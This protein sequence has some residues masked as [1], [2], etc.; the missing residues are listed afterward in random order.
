[1][2]TGRRDGPAP[3]PLIG[4]DKYEWIRDLNAGT[5]GFVQVCHCLLGNTAPPSTVAVLACLRVRLELLGYR[6]RSK[7][8]QLTQKCVYHRSLPSTGTVGSR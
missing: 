3:R 8:E 2:A 7:L 5:Y 4:H 6:S 1:M